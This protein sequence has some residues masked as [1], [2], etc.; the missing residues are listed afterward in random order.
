MGSLSA[1]TDVFQVPVSADP[2]FTSSLQ[3]DQ[4]S[5][6][7]IGS[8]DDQSLLAEA[9]KAI[10]YEPPVSLVADATVCM[11]RRLHTYTRPQLVDY[12]RK[13]FPGIPEYLQ[14]TMVTVAT[15]AAHYVASKFVMYDMGKDST[16]QLM[17]DDAMAARNVLARWSSGLR[18]LEP[19]SPLPVTSSLFQSACVGAQEPATMTNAASSLENLLVTRAVPVPLPMGDTIDPVSATDVL[20]GSCAL[21]SLQTSKA[22]EVVSSCS[23]SRSANDV[24]AADVP[25]NMAPGAPVSKAR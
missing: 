18:V 14:D 3:I 15:S 17:R 7:A 1:G 6:N 5:T 19:G 8:A 4:A 24:N 12:L 25:D 13:Y 11:L 10:D 20:T 22:P 2:C 16:N 9:L 23:D 21:S